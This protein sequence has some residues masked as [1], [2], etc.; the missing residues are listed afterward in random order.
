MVPEVCKQV[1][2]SDQQIH[3]SYLVTMYFLIT[4]ILMIDGLYIIVVN[5]LHGI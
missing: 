2:E 3:S 4:F 5:Y 1:N